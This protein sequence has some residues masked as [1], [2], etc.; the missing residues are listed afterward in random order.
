MAS[1][2]LIPLMSNILQGK[3]AMPRSLRTRVGCRVDQLRSG[4]IA[5]ILAFG[6]A[7]AA[8]ADDDRQTARVPLLPKYQQECSACHVAYPPGLLPKA[9]WQRLMGNLPQHFGTDASLDPATQKELAAWLDA[10]AGT[11]KRAS[12]APPEDRITR[13]AW[14]IRKHDE[15]PAATWKRPAIKSASNC[16]ACHTQADQGDFSESRVHIPR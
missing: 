15:V 2:S 9:S 5:L 10:H 1:R 16:G 11:G 8:L 4:P 6:A 13:T 14:F 3:P 7:H 12:E